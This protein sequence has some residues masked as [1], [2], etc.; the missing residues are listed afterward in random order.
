MFNIID[1]HD[2]WISTAVDLFMISFFYFK[3]IKG[4]FLTKAQ[5]DNRY[6]PKEY[7]DTKL[8][9]IDNRLRD[10]VSREQLEKLEELVMKFRDELKDDFN[11]IDDKLDKII[12]RE[13]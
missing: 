7:I 6:Y 8:A 5:N 13:R 9:D 11:K 2:L 10:A 3:I 4:D 12:L 1:K